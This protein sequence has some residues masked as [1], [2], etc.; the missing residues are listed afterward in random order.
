MCRSL[1][2]NIIGNLTRETDGACVRARPIYDTHIR[3]E[4]AALRGTRSFP[5][6]SNNPGHICRLSWYPSLS[7]QWLPCD[8]YARILAS[9]WRYIYSDGSV[10]LLVQSPR[11]ITTSKLFRLFPMYCSVNYSRSRRP[12]CRLS[13]SYFLGRDFLN[14]HCCLFYAMPIGY[15]DLDA[16]RCSLW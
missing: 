5:G 2:R 3:V 7:P 8:L 11:K 4:R 15:F 12:F 14:S 13:Y 10:R 9:R 16:G 1:E 6:I